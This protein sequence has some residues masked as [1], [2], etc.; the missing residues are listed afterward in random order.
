MSHARVALVTG[1]SQGIGRAVA[2]VLA[3][4]GYAV[5]GVARSHDKLL[6]WAE[7]CAANGATH[8]CWHAADLREPEAATQAV[9]STLAHFGRLDL[10][11]HSA[12]TTKRGDFFAL[13]DEDFAD[14]FALK[15]HGAVRLA[16][17]AWPHLR[18][19]GSGHLINI[20][21]AGGRTPS[22]DFT[23]GGPVNSALMNFT[24]ALADKGLSDGVRVNGINPGPIETDRLKARIAQVMKAGNI[25]EATARARMVAD[26]KV[27]RF[28]RPEEVGE[29]VA[30]LDSQAGAFMHGAIVD[31]DGG[32]TKGL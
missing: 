31:L 16:R 29:M 9:A 21:G 22:A 11:V 30:F 26:Q 14:G 32:L 25:D 6:E 7:N 10:V 24:K 12:G 17:S 27:I 28:G 23:I 1:A 18:S 19:G 5:A 4:R 3:V 15:F 2:T 20:I 13:T 8:T